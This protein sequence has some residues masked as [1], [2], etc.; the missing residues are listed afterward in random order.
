M[1]TVCSVRGR[2]SFWLGLLDAIISAVLANVILFPV[3]YFLPFMIAN[4]NSFQTKTSVPESVVK[5]QLAKLL[6]RFKCARNA[7]VAPA[8]PTF[9][10]SITGT[11]TEAAPLAHIRAVVQL[12]YRP[13]DEG[14]NTVIKLG[15]DTDTLDN[16]RKLRRKLSE[17]H[18]RDN[19]ILARDHAVVANQRAAGSRPCRRGSKLRELVD[20]RS[21]RFCC[22]PVQL[23]KTGT[24]WF[25]HTHEDKFD[26]HD[27]KTPE[28]L[29]AIAQ[30]QGHVR[31]RQQRR[32]ALRAVEFDAWLRDM[33]RQRDTL[34][35]IN[36]IFVAVLSVF[37]LV[38][39]IFLSA[40]FSEEECI[41]WVV[42]VGQSL[43]VGTCASDRGWKN[44][45]FG[46]WLAISHRLLTPF[47]R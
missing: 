38:I 46:R 42:N 22:V 25:R 24:A 13:A 36:S 1:L 41:D 12:W 37:T 14:K 29:K 45:C 3:Q 7:S 30:F 27:D 39:C 8:G 16:A 33:K 35:L 21:L 2:N 10:A 32:M 4:V 47:L 23:P 11:S 31:H 26:V 20:V 9:L 5:Q 19:P 44:V 28:K 6:R 34:S 18:A 43:V 17:R 40:A 15:T